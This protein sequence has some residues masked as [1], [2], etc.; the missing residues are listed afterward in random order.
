MFSLKCVY[1]IF[2]HHNF[3]REYYKLPELQ[4]VKFI[5]LRASRDAT[6]AMAKKSYSFIISTWL[7]MSCMYAVLVYTSE[8]ATRDETTDCPE[9]WTPFDGACYRVYNTPEKWEKAEDS[10]QRHE[11]SHLVSIH[12]LEEH[13]FVRDLYEAS[14]HSLRKGFW[15]GLKTQE[16]WDSQVWTDGTEVTFRNFK[17][18]PVV[19][20]CM[21]I[22]PET[23]DNVKWN[24]KKSCKKTL[25]FVCKFTAKFESSPSSPPTE[26]PAPNEH[27]QGKSKSALFYRAW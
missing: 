6:T 7:H 2:L 13:I 14:P 3:R 23:S 11:N 20:K 27:D 10:C 15:I 9:N 22:R 26:S 4:Y 8:A 17:N 12:S 24:F 1:V 16:Q 21:R 19:D 25:H 18:T 5:R